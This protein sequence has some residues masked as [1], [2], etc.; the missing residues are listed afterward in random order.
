MYKFVRVSRVSHAMAG[1]G[2]EFWTHGKQLKVISRE[3]VRTICF[4]LYF[5]LEMRFTASMCPT[6]TL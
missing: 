4:S 1:W 5:G 6:S 3:G 2:G